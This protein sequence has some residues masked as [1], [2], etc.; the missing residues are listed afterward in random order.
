M[1]W[2]ELSPL[3]VYKTSKDNL[4]IARFSSNPKYSLFYLRFYSIMVIFSSRDVAVMSLW[5][6]FGNQFLPKIL[7][8]QFLE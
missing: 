7:C 2:F 8:S 1:Y 3:H 6:S 5:A 4:V